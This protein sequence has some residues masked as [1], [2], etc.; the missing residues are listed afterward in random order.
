MRQLLFFVS[1]NF[2]YKQRYSTKFRTLLQKGYEPRHVFLICNKFLD[3]TKGP[4]KKMLLQKG[5]KPRHHYCA[6]IG[7]FEVGTVMISGQDNVFS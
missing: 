5:Y 1:N 4:N 3:E 6:I 7:Y 2:S